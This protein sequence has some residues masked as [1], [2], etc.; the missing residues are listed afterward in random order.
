[1]GVIVAGWP[2]RQ[3]GRVGFGII[4]RIFPIRFCGAFQFAPVKEIRSIERDAD[5]FFSEQQ[6][7]NFLPRLA[8]LAQ[9]ADEIKVWFQDAVEWFA[10]AFSLCRFVITGQNSPVAENRG[11]EQVK[12][13][14]R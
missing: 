5:A 10:A 13:K 8:P 4:S 2:L 12:V 9:L 3:G 14:V 6:F 1:M 7:G 11:R